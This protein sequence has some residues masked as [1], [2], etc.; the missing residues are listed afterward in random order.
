MR[1]ILLNLDL[2]EKEQE[3]KSLTEFKNRVKD[4]ISGKTKHL[5]IHSPS[6]LYSVDIEDIKLVEGAKTF[7]ITY[8]KE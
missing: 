1:K 5:L 7:T 3:P 8:K 6:N 4:F 2:S